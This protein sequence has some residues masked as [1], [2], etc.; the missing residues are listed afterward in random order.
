[1]S[2]RGLVVAVLGPDGAG[3]S[4]LIENLGQRFSALG[5][6]WRR[7]HWRVPWTVA[8]RP[9]SPVPDP[10]ARPPRGTL[11]SVAKVLWYLITAWP[12]WWRN[13][14]PFTRRGGWVVLDRCFT[15]LLCDPRRYRYGGPRWLARLVAA[16]MP[17]PDR[18]LVLAGDAG[19]IAA[20]KQEVAFA[21]LERQVA[22]YRAAGSARNALVID[23]VATPERVTAAACSGLGLGAAP[24]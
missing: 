2:G 13:V 24:C 19:A 15:D 11:P 8:E 18:V 23:C 1:M 16:L 5:V 4:T 10:H 12:C 3:K 17:R 6:P 20:R 7:F 14:R 21:E 9:W 22:A